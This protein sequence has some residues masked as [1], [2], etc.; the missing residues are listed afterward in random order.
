MSELKK[1]IKKLIPESLLGVMRK[2][3]RKLKE[4][5]TKILVP[6]DFLNEVYR[7]KVGYEKHKNEIETL[8]LRGS[9]ADYG[10]YANNM[11]SVYNLGLN[12]SDL[13]INYQLFDSLHESTP[14]LKNIVLFFSV[15]TPGMSLIKTR[16]KYRCV[17]YKHFFGIDYQD[18][19]N[20]KKSLEKRIIKRIKK[21]KPQDVKHSYNGYEKKY[22]FGSFENAENRVRTHIR[23]NKRE[24]DQMIWLDRLI[25]ESINKNFKIYIV[26]PPVSSNYKLL[27]PSQDELFMKL[28]NTINDRCEVIS[29]YDSNKFDDSDLGDT[30]HLNEKGAKK[31]TSE[32]L[33]VIN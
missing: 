27:L 21:I 33:S 2:A 18:D 4:N 23:E 25:T 26:I 32:V 3:K 14:N 12:S 9:H 6:D 28:H 31:L 20:L 24:P 15:F 16:E 7:K 19:N 8:V 13:Y 17:V 5:D 11:K 29:F 30:D 22:S 10:F 1:E